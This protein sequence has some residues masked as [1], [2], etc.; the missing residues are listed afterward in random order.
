MKRGL[1]I[2]V[3]VLVVLIVI[4]IAIPFFIDANVFRPRLESD[5]SA[6]LGRQVKVGNLSLSLLSGGVKAD[7]ISIADDPVFHNPPFLPA[8][9]L[10]M[11]LQF[12]PLIFPNAS[13]P[14]NP[15]HT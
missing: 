13:Q 10:P 9:S 6:T 15:T 7:D 11:W 14:T 4:V 3:I 2:F 8:Q 5:L 12:L 1:N